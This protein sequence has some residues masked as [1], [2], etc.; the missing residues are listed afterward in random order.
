MSSVDVINK[1]Y[2]FKVV[3]KYEAFQDIQPNIASANE[4][5]KAIVSNALNTCC[6]HLI[7]LFESNKKPTKL[8]LKQSITKCMNNLSKAE[9]DSENRDFGY[10]LCWFLAEKVGLDLKHASANRI[11]GYWEVN[12]NEVMPIYS[13]SKK[14]SNN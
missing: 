10:E 1:L 14:K 12:E 9:I 6:I 8:S 7:Q 4:A 13:K 3:D 2:A 5:C 11:W